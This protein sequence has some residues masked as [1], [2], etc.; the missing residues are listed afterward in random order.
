M[1]MQ[2]EMLFRRLFALTIG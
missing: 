1:T 2:M